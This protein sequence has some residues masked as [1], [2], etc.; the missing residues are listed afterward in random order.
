MSYLPSLSTPSKTFQP[1]TASGIVTAWN[2]IVTVNSATPVTITLPAI[3]AATKGLDIQIVKLG[4]GAVSITSAAG[5]TLQGVAAGT[6]AITL[7]GNNSGVDISN[8]GATVAVAV[9]DEWSSLG[10]SVQTKTATAGTPVA[11][12]L[13]SVDD[14]IILDA[15]LNNGTLTLPKANV[16]GSVGAEKTYSVKLVGLGGGFAANIA[17]TAGDTIEVPNSSPPTFGAASAPMTVP[18]IAFRLT[19]DS[20]NS[21][22][23]LN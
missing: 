5:S 13:A 14:F 21:R 16:V 11:Y 17:I 10:N 2:S 22:W 3:S 1:L 4:V 8:D 12:T 23:F 19:G 6:A 7:Q 15:T 20:L 9:E 18:G